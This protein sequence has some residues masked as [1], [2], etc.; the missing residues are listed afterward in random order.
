MIPSPASV[1]KYTMPDSTYET[2]P[3]SVLAY[4]KSHKIGRFDP[5][6][7]EIQKRKVKEMWKEIEEQSVCNYINHS[8]N[9]LYH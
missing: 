1:P 3:D 7:P 4:K 5:S 2:I 6:V 9:S 8:I